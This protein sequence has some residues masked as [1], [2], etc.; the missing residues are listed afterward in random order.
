MQRRSPPAPWYNRST[1]DRDI[2]FLPDYNTGTAIIGGG[3]AGLWI[4][5]VLDRAGHDVI[6]IERDALGGQQTLASQGMIHGGIKYTLGGFTTPASETIAGMPAR[7][8]DCIAGHGEIDLRGVRMLSEDYFL[9]SDERLSSKITAFFGSRSLRGRIEPVQR[10]DYP[11]AFANDRFRGTIYR[12]EDIVLDTAS[13]LEQLARN[14]EGHILKADATAV[15]GDTGNIDHLQLAGGDT[16]RAD[17]YIF[18]AGA[19]NERLL[20]NSPL[21]AVRMQRRPLKQVMVTLP[22]LPRLYAHAVSAGAGAKPRVTIT[23][24]EGSD[25]TIS[26]YLG[27]ELA[28]AGVRRTDAEQIDAAGEEMARLFPWLEWPAARWCTLDIDRAEPLDPAGRRPDTPFV[29]QAGNAIVCWPTKLTLT[30]LAGDEV[31]DRLANV[32]IGKSG[33]SRPPLPGVEIARSPWD[34]AFST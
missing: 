12:L 28:E 11:A 1:P 31:L 5:N 24:H 26:W 7:W 10:D 20:A 34:K 19:G 15:R 29:E 23:T 25:G 2:P 32:D 27:G 22:G 21:S 16:L 13:L 30:P 33:S 17:A 9:F 6:L 8:R 4:A 18:A 3:V 14:I